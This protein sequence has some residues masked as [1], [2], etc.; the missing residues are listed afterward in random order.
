MIHRIRLNED[1]ADGPYILIGSE[2]RDLIGR[3]IVA[4]EYS[5][6]R[7]FL[8]LSPR[9][10]ARNLYDGFGEAQQRL[11]PE[12]STKEQIKNDE[13]YAGSTVCIGFEPMMED[14]DD[15]YFPAV[16]S[17]SFIRAAVLGEIFHYPQSNP[18]FQLGF[19]TQQDGQ[20]YREREGRS[21]EIAKEQRERAE[22]E[23]LKAKFDPDPGPQIARI[24]RGMLGKSQRIWRKPSDG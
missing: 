11:S 22:Y 8:K 2:M 24:K 21:L 3:V 16:W 5:G 18:F 1:W 12:N 13:T 19:I 23:R 7:L 15:G 14:Q 9:V 10:P 20:D 6:N 17:P 4:A